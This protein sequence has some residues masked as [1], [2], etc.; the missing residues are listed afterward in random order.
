MRAHLVACLALLALAAPAAALVP[1]P[2]ECALI[3][4]C[5]SL[6]LVKKC[7]NC[8]YRIKTEQ[9]YKAE[10]QELFEKCAGQEGYPNATITVDA[11]PFCG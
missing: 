3:L 1:P 9:L 7:D 6:S 10:V 11:G 4:E 5:T 8:Y 2:A